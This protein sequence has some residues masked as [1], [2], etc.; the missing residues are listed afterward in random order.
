VNTPPL[1]EAECYERSYG[2]HVFDHV[3]V[4]PPS[5][6]WEKG[7]PAIAWDDDGTAHVTTEGLKRQFEERLAARKRRN[8][9]KPGR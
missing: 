2:E 3:D 9:K 8:H 1:G 5:H 7:I 6:P 4:V